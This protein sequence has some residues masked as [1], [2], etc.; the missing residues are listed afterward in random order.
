MNDLSNRSLAMLSVSQAQDELLCR[1]V[2]QAVQ[3][4]ATEEEWQQVMRDTRALLSMK[5][6][7]MVDHFEGHVSEDPGAQLVR[8]LV[9]EAVP[10]RD[11][12]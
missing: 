3:N 8:R 11:G 6:F 4:G 9:A 1:T 5:F 12:E 10:I 2:I 7:E